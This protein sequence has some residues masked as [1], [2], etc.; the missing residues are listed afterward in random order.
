MNADAGGVVL[1]GQSNKIFI[2]RVATYHVTTWVIVRGVKDCTCLRKIYAHHLAA[3]EKAK[4]YAMGAVACVNTG[5]WNPP[6]LV[7]VLSRR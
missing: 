1:P 4:E 5:I 2:L 3:E 6:D 7:V